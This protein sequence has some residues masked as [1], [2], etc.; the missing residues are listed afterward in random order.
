V[1]GRNAIQVADPHAFQA[2]LC[3]VVRR[4]ADPESAAAAHG[5]ETKQAPS[6]R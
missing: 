4:G 5:L 1:F 6:R 2:A 3:D